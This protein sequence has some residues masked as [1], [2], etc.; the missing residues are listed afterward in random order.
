LNFAL[1]GDSPLGKKTTLQS[2]K[3]ITLDDVKQWYKR[4]YRPNDALL[5]I[6]GD[7]TVKRGKELAET[8]LAGWEPADQLPKADY[9]PVEPSKTRRIVLIDNPNGKQ[10]TI[11]MAARA[12][13]IHSDEK[14]AGSA[15]GRILSD[16]I[17]S[18]LD[19]YLRAE[20]G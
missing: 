19:R 6:S 15:V 3:S 13:D 14:F 17:H 12:F 4:V 20:K 8:L 1:F 18:R 7:V 16:G 9:T 11:R 10:S 2:I 5:L